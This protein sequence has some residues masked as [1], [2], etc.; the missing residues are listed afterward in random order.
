MSKVTLKAVGDIILGGVVGAEISRLGA[1]Y[2][3]DHVRPVLSDCDMTIGNLETPLTN[4]EN[5]DVTKKFVYRAPVECAVSLKNSGLTIANIANNHIM[6]YGHAGLND[7]IFAL[8]QAG[9]QCVGAGSNVLDACKPLLVTTNGIKVALL[10]F[11]YAT[12]AKRNKAGCCSC[13]SAFMGKQI[14][15]IR[16]EADLIVASIHHGVE[17]VDYPNR[18]MVRLFR[19]AADAGADLIIG[20]HPHVVQGIEFYRGALIAY[21]LGNFVSGYAD[22]EERRHSYENTALTCFGG[23]TL[24]I[25]D[26]RTTEGIILQCTL[27]KKG[28]MDY[29]LMPVK[30]NDRFQTMLMTDMEAN[31][32]VQKVETLSEKFAS[33]DDPVFDAMDVLWAKCRQQQLSNM[34]FFTITKKLHLIRPRHF[35]SLIPYLKAKFTDGRNS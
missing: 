5:A 25:D 31:A 17:Y 22:T 6:D 1:D 10:A 27:G 35:K 32:F 30:S 28:V 18:D 11:T 20:H 2:I 29:Q 33:L 16:N 4:R 21:S 12:N 24:S 14:R 34:E 26:M 8:K 7:T 13:D 23:K 19:S 9:V 3:F 15:K